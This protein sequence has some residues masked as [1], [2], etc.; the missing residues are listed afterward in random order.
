MSEMKEKYE[1]FVDKLG[2]T[3]ENE[4]MTIQLIGMSLFFK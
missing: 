4:Q 1:G 3:E 2:E